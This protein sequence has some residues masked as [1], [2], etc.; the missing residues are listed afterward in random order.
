MRS[1]G[2]KE[3][4][5]Q[6]IYVEYPPR[7]GQVAGAEAIAGGGDAQQEYSRQVEAVGGIGAGAAYHQDVLESSA[8]RFDV[9]PSR[10]FL[11]EH[12]GEDKYFTSPPFRRREKERTATSS[13]TS[14]ACCLTR[15][16]IPQVNEF[17]RHTPGK[18]GMQM[19]RGHAQEHA[20]FLLQHN[21]R[22]Q[23]TSIQQRTRPRVLV[24][25]PA[26]AVAS[27]STTPSASELLRS[28]R[29]LLRL[30][31]VTPS[32]VGDVAPSVSVVDE[33]GDE[34]VGR[35]R[36]AVSSIRSAISSRVLEEEEE[37][38]RGGSVTASRAIHTTSSKKLCKEKDHTRDPQVEEDQNE[39]PHDDGGQGD[40][41]P[42]TFWSVA[43]VTRWAEDRV[44][45]EVTRI[46]RQQEVDGGVLM[47]LNESD[48]ETLGIAK[49]GHRRTLLLKIRQMRDEMKRIFS[50]Y[51]RRRIA[52]D[53]FQVEDDTAL[54][55]QSCTSPRVRGSVASSSADVHVE[56]KPRS[57]TSSSTFDYS[58]KARSIPASI[59]WRPTRQSQLT[60][61]FY[62]SGGREGGGGAGGGNGVG[63]ESRRGG[64][65]VRKDAGGGGGRGR[66]PT[67][68][69]DPPS[70]L[71][72]TSSPRNVAKF[73]AVSRGVGVYPLE[74][75]GINPPAGGAPGR[76]SLSSSSSSPSSTNGL[77]E[78]CRAGGGTSGSNGS[79][80]VG[81]RKVEAD[82]KGNPLFLGRRSSC[83]TSGLSCDTKNALLF[84]SSC[85]N[86]NLN[87]MESCCASTLVSSFSRSCGTI[88]YN[89][90]SSSSCR[91]T[92][93]KGQAGGAGVEPNCYRIA[94]DQVTRSHKIRVAVQQAQISKD[95]PTPVR[96]TSTL[97]VANDRGRSWLNYRNKAP[98]FEASPSTSV[99]SAGAHVSYICRV[100]VDVSSIN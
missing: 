6:Q 10:P 100:P 16:R 42:P 21:Q 88:C 78:T 53:S 57:S 8:V 86:L 4:H 96:R 80:R 32:R 52:G 24:E 69:S 83:T 87:S 98:L 25:S 38:L 51:N 13:T 84:S 2:G 61:Y 45:A 23:H 91:S 9:F 70:L 37:V 81:H 29:A 60:N 12:G 27:T 3:Y 49:F 35:R 14:A 11:D 85:T 41:H 82:E 58:F 46:L 76:M 74:G 92:S 48:M 72:K 19:Q 90:S 67:S 34:K 94:Y 17:S 62:N 39:A 79:P 18:R 54:L 43:R 15:S 97:A 64:G 66:A 44:P 1:R 93:I 59:G 73:E 68:S 30:G 65:E 95:G 71:T 50:I 28:A 77:V 47:S 40:E 89:S 7:R 75:G 63:G 20:D 33:H 56:S 26:D 31:K 36:R 99:T 22:D 5:V 55:S